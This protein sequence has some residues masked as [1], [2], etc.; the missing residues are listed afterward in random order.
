LETDQILRFE[1]YLKEYKD[2]VYRVAYY[3][4]KNKDDAEDL[5]QEAFMRAFRFFSKFRPDTNF[6]SW[7]LKIMRNIYITNFN[8]NKNQV[9][10][11]KTSEE[12]EFMG[13]NLEDKMIDEMRINLIRESIQL[14]PDDFKE[15]I[16]LCDIEGLSYEEIAKI[17]KIPVGT[18]R[19]R[20]HRGRL[21][22]KER[23][24]KKE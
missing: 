19:S 20:L 23:L 2:D 22:L 3:Y 15:V 21:L 11:T 18:V 5:S 12:Y 13:T 4:T 1:N 24:I 14:L 8:K 17:I 10:I 16:L 9:E 7:I 6:K